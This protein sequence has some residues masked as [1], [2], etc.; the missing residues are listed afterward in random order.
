MEQG[1]DDDVDDPN[2]LQDNNTY[3]IPR[4]ADLLYAIHP[5]YDTLLECFY[6]Y[7]QQFYQKQEGGNYRI[8]KNI[9]SPTKWTIDPIM[10][11]VAMSSMI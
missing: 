8:F 10:T 1:F 6:V 3:D 5:L 7:T 2:Q 4:M 9:A 11:D